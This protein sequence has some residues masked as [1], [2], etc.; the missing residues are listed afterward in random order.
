[1]RTQSRLEVVLAGWAIVFA[2]TTVGGWWF[3]QRDYDDTGAVVALPVGPGRGVDVDIWLHDAVATFWPDAPSSAR[4]SHRTMIPI[5]GHFTVAVWYQD[6]AAATSTRLG[7]V[8]LPIWP[9]LVMAAAQALVAGWIWRR[10]GEDDTAGKG[11]A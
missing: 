7:I 2:L 4:P 1:M 11:G 9:L 5:R 8:R 3:A 10:A 6:T